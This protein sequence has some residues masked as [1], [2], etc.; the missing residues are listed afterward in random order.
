MAQVC[1]QRILDEA[2]RLLTA[3]GFADDADE[4]A[5]DNCVH[6]LKSLSRALWR[7]GIHRIEELHE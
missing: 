4:E 1:P 3:A 5:A 6:E 2:V 7:D